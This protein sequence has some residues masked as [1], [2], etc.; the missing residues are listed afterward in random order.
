[1]PLELTSPFF[2]VVAPPL[3]QAIPPA[4]ITNWHGSL[5][6]CPTVTAGTALNSNP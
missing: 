1:M 3:Q 6:A 4:S 5:L 2:E